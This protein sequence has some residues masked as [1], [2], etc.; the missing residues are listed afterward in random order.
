MS[1]FLDDNQKF[2]HLK[3]V[4]NL[5]L[6]SPWGTKEHVTRDLCKY[7]HN[8]HQ[9]VVHREPGSGGGLLTC[10]QDEVHA[11]GVIPGLGTD[12]LGLSLCVLQLLQDVHCITHSVTHTH[13][14]H[15]LLSQM[16][17]GHHKNQIRTCLTWFVVCYLLSYCRVGNNFKPSIQR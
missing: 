16:T 7:Q 14:Q 8:W 13:R 4:F 11:A 1:L 12:V 5:E 6:F 10:L 15:T 3:L 17:S 9:K 2:L